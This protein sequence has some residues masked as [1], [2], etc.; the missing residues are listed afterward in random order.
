M[1]YIYLLILLPF[2]IIETQI[3]STEKNISLNEVVV[4]GSKFE[5]QRSTLPNQISLISKK[6]NCLSEYP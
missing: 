5:A 2:T 1:K 6:P 4:S 3:D